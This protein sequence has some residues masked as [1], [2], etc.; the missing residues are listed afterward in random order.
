MKKADVINSAYWYA[1]DVE[2]D[3]GC[4]SEDLIAEFMEDEMKVPYS[5]SGKW[6]H[7]VM[8]KLHK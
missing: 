7:E 5:K 6:A 8:K 4:V 2:N 3:D 1:V